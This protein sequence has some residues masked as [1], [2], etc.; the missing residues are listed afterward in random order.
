MP[1][2]IA[3]DIARQVK[4]LGEEIVEEAKELPGGMVRAAGEQIGI[5]PR[6]WGEESEAQ[7][8]TR[9]IQEKKEE[10]E[11][12]LA[13]ARKRIKELSPQPSQP[14]P[15]EAPEEIKR[16]KELTKEAERKKEVP[17]VPGKKPRGSALLSL[18]VKKHRGTG[19][20]RTGL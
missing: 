14:K 16:Q 17:K 19:E 15:E 6:G 7:L 4:Q 20:I 11:K 5:L 8:S 9:L 2:K 3:R 10:E 18:R 1:K 13:F 12:E